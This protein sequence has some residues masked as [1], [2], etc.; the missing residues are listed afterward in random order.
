M[1]FVAACSRVVGILTCRDIDEKDGVLYS[2]TATKASTT[3]V[4]E[5]VDVSIAVVN[6]IATIAIVGTVLFL[7][8]MLLMIFNDMKESEVAR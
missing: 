4:L 7:F 1:S 3:D 2:D 5:L 8:C 6:T